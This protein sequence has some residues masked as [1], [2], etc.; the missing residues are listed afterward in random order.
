MRRP[1]DEV[2]AVVRDTDPDVLDSAE[3]D[4]YLVTVSRLRAWCDA[5]Q[6]RATRRQR[7]L[8]TEGHAAEPE[9]SLSNHG[10]QSAK[11]AKASAEREQTCTAMPAFEDALADG[12]VSSGHVDAIAAATRNLDDGELAEFVGESNSLLSTAEQQGVDRFA[13]ECRDLAKGIR[14]RHNAQADVDELERQRH[15][16]KV[17]RW[18][19]KV[20]GMHKTLIEC[21]PL[22]DRTI[23][24]AVQR[25]RGR[26]RQRDHQT[27][28]PKPT[29]D[30][31]TVDSFADA[32]N[33]G[34]AGASAVVTH[35]D[36]ETLIDG[37]HERGL[38]ETDSGVPLPI[39]TVR[40]LACD[41][42][43]IPVVLD[44]DGIVL[45]QG[46]AKRLA[47][48]EQRTAIQAMQATCSHPDCTVSID[49]CRIHH[50][51]PWS[52][53]GRS[54]LDTMAPVCERH[55]HLVHEGGWTFTITPHRVATWSR[56]DGE[57][58]WSGA[59]NDRHRVAG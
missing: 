14:A 53:G 45:D 7:Q 9:H 31:L 51:E 2:F 19:D 39:D 15:Q 24:S 55:H 34:Q 27:S 42:D 56:P 29:W 8:A 22:T 43:I 41:A 33:G 5:R 37:L 38:C 16:S 3:L 46:R 52:R 1:P 54:D 12:S 40:R 36:L 58:Y 13:K 49:D 11:D 23:W 35:I 6:V 44:G 25:T 21:D 26:L 48:P 59:I 17:T 50:I 4:E 57:E 28:G 30:R 20:T 32:L 47:T 18:V 10:R